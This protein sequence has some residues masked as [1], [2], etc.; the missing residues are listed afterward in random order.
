MSISALS[1]HPSFLTL[2]FCRECYTIYCSI[3]LCYAIWPLQY[4]YH[5]KILERE[6]FSSLSLKIPEVMNMQIFSFHK[7]FPTSLFHAQC[8]CTGGSL[9]TSLNNLSFEMN[10][11][12]NILF[13]SQTL[14]IY[15]STVTQTKIFNCRNKKRNT[16][17]T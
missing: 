17:L 7:M 9:S 14:H 11:N 10:F 2:L 4:N 3:M 5:I 13:Q 15:D 16:P 6:H 8:M 12:K 1:H